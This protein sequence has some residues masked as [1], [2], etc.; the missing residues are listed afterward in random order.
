MWE[1]VV[2]AVLVQRTVLY[3]AYRI[4]PLVTAIKVGSFNDTAAR[5]AEYAGLQ[6]LQVLH[7]ISTKQTLPSV[8][9]EE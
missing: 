7:E 6:I 4:L 3:G 9:G 1:C 5:E 8:I 2:P